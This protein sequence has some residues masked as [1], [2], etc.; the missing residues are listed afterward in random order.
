LQIFTYFPKDK[1]VID[2]VI[3]KDDRVTGRIHALTFRG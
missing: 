3:D 1:V 2:I